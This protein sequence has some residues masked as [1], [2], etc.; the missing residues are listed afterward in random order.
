MDQEN[1]YLEVN[2][3]MC[4]EHPG[5]SIYLWDCV[6]TIWLWDISAETAGF[7][8]NTKQNVPFGLGILINK[9]KTM[10]PNDIQVMNGQI[11]ILRRVFKSKWPKVTIDRWLI[12]MKMCDMRQTLELSFFC[13]EI[14]YYPRS[15]QYYSTDLGQNNLGKNCFGSLKIIS[16][17]YVGIRGSP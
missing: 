16:I 2:D 6:G 4:S 14:N 5:I 10:F 13:I 7:E 3:F 1:E 15:D 9:S 12:S 11:K 8:L 17:K